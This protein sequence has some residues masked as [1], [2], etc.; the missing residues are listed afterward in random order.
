MNNRSIVKP[1]E[2]PILHVHLDGP[3]IPFVKELK[4]HGVVFTSQRSRRDIV[5]ASSV[6][7]SA[8]FVRP[9]AYLSTY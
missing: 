4:F 2:Y 8:L 6:R 9:E 7:P 1:Y 3:T 5:L